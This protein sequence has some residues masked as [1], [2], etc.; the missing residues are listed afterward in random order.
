M[1]KE[2]GYREPVQKSLQKIYSANYQV[3]VYIFKW[4]FSTN[5]VKFQIQTARPI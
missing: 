1:R 3:E 2:L 4:I 5:F